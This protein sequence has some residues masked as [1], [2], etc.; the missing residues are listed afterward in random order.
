MNIKVFYHSLKHSYAL[1]NN[2]MQ[3]SAKLCEVYTYLNFPPF[4]CPQN[5]SALF[6]VRASNF[7]I[8]RSTKLSCVLPICERKYVENLLLQ[9]PGV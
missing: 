6:V 5:F 9:S 2:L 4:L 7:I 8:C 3:T 1:A